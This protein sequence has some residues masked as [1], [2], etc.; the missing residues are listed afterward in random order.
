MVFETAT[1]VSLRSLQETEVYTRGGRR[2]GPVDFN[3]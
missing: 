3:G 1:T 2:E